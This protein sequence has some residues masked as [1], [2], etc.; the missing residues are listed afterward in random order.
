MIVL[1]TKDFDWIKIVQLAAK[2]LLSEKDA[3][4]IDAQIR[5][6]G[7]QI[8]LYRTDARTQCDCEDPVFE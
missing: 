2:V 6:Q 3:A 5:P 4:H 7:S 8:G 1:L